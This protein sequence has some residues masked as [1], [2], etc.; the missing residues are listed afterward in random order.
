MLKALCTLPEVT[1]KYLL[2]RV[3]EVDP[4]FVCGPVV[5][6]AAFTPVVMQER[7]VWCHKYVNY[8]PR[9]WWQWV[10][11]DEFTVYEKPLPE[12]YIHRR[13]DQLSATNPDLKHFDFG[14]Y[15]KLS[16]CVA[17]NG[18]IGLVGYWW[19]HST[20]GLKGPV[21]TVSIPPFLPAHVPP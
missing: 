4:G 5:T 9:W 13:G 19:I 1:P 12:R 15:G 7:L 10:F 6:K 2:A 8:S 21:Y 11:V 17:V 16:L 14:G 3:K 20:T 18:Y